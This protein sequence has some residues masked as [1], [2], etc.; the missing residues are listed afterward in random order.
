[1]KSATFIFIFLLSI[2]I[3]AA[4]TRATNPLDTGLQLILGGNYEQAEKYF[5]PLLKDPNLKQASLRNLST[6]YMKT[7]QYDKAVELAEKALK[8]KPSG[9]E[10]LLLMGNAYCDKA[11]N[12]SMFKALKLGKKCIAQFDDA[13]SNHPNRVDALLYASKIHFQ[14][15]SMIGGSKKK[16]A[17]YFDKL[18]KVSPEHAKTYKISMLE[19][20]GEHEEATRLANELASEVFVSAINQYDIARFFQLKKEHEIAKRLYEPLTNTTPSLDTHW[21]ITDS[22]L[23]L[24]EVYISEGEAP[25]VGVNLIERYKEKNTN[26]H[27]MHYFWST[28]ILAIG[29]KAIGDMDKYHQLVDQIKSEDYK[30]DDYFAKEFEAN[31]WVYID[32]SSTLLNAQIQPEH[33]MR[34]YVLYSSTLRQRA[35]HS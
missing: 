24:G 7:G 17:I 8:N 26:K 32:K 15:P 14:A 3:H 31:I 33:L 29:Y 27:D 18:M 10:E 1:M 25:K 22:L 28:W 2:G 20:E 16:A 13:V 6:I 11:Q 4:E 5:M 12:S 34:Y 19:S 21:H 9:L 23:Q 30:K 35:K